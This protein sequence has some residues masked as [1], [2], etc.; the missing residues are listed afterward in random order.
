M[1][2]RYSRLATRCGVLGAV[3]LAVAACS[4]TVSSPQVLPSALASAGGAATVSPSPPPSPSASPVVPGRCLV[5][6]ERYC[7]SATIVTLTAAPG[8]ASGMAYAALTLPA[9]TPIFAPA[10]GTTTDGAI[11]P[12]YGSAG[13]AVD[14]P[15]AGIQVV[16]AAGTVTA[17]WTLIVSGGLAPP[18]GSHVEQGDVIGTAPSTQLLGP[19]NLLVQYAGHA[20]AGGL[21]QRVTDLMARFGPRDWGV[22]TRVV[23][24]SLK[25]DLPVIE[26]PAQPAPTLC[27]VAYHLAQSPQP[28]SAGAVYLYANARQGMFLPLLTA[29]KTNDGQSMMGQEVQVYTSADW[30]FTYVISGIHRHQRQLPAAVMDPAAPAQLWLQTG[31]GPPG[32]PNLLVVAVLIDAPTIDQTAAHPTAHPVACN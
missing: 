17:V 7:D 8:A 22:A 32:S 23:I 5:V 12:V 26:S 15:L 6:E 9:G 4:A 1:K 13:Q 24:P 31:E 14:L 21:S 20:E 18:A 10:T 2:R 16:S 29:S 11:Q 3:A 28:G 30:R 19:N 27:G 25:I